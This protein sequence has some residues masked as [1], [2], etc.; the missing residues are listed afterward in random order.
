MSIDINML[1]LI[2]IC[3]T[4]VLISFLKHNIRRY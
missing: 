3:F 1:E 2:T 4:V